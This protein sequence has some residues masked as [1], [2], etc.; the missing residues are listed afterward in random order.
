MFTYIPIYIYIS[1][2]THIYVHV[3][4][5]TFVVNLY[6]RLFLLWRCEIVGTASTEGSSFELFMYICLY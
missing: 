6:K 2:C 3:H 1:I 4:M 5:Y